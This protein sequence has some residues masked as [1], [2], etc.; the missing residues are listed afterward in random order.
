MYPLKLLAT[1]GS[2]VMLSIAP[3]AVEHQPSSTISLTL[4]REYGR[5]VFSWCR[6]VVGLSDGAG[7]ATL[8]CRYNG[9]D[10][11]GQ[12]PLLTAE[13]VLTSSEANTLTD[14]VKK[15]NLY[16]G[17]ASG[18]D[19]TAGDGEFETLAVNTDGRV[20]VLV[21]TGNPSFVQFHPRRELRSHLV[22]IEKRL[23]DKGRAR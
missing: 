23:L 6:L 9:P 5:A 1:V 3:S 10:G 19:E 21:T 7:N 12:P 22:T 11:K 4:N 18:T 15:S 13:E 20:V 16:K 2:I 14:L 8:Q 17:E